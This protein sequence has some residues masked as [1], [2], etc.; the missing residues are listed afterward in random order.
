MCICVRAGRERT[1][2]V[3]SL[4][5]DIGVIILVS[6]QFLSKKIIK[7]IF[8]LKTLKPVQTDRFGYFR[9]KTKN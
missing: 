3:M 1:C 4:N 2:G 5:S 6:I 8:F 7:L 9:A